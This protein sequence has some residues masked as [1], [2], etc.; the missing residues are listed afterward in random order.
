MLVPCPSLESHMIRI[1]GLHGMLQARLDR[2]I[3]FLKLLQMK[4]NCKSRSRAEQLLDRV[5]DFEKGLVHNDL[6][7][8]EWAP[9]SEVYEPATGNATSVRTAGA[10]GTAKSPSQRKRLA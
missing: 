1:E 10:L 4:A 3:V 7:A 9:N 5:I 8:N 6:C 2:R